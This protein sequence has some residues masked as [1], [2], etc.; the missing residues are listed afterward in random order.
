MPQPTVAVPLNRDRPVVHCSPAP[1]TQVVRDGVAPLWA[2]LVAAPTA[3]GLAC[4]I[5]PLPTMT[6]PAMVAGAGFDGGPAILL[7]LPLFAIL[8]AIFAGPFALP[9]ILALAVRGVRSVGAHVGLGIVA[10]VPAML[11]FAATMEGLATPVIGAILGGGALGGLTVSAVRDNAERW[12]CRYEA[13]LRAYR[14][15]RFH[16]AA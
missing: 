8:T 3:F 14:I 7:T 16:R 10:S 2:R 13:Y 11:L 5:A 9:I 6:L 12:L 15:E 1:T 4:V